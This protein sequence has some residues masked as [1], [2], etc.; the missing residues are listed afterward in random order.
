MVLLDSARECVCVLCGCTDSRACHGGCSWVK[1]DRD[2]GCGLCSA[3]D[4]D[5]ETIL[6]IPGKAGKPTEL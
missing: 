4:V 6:L 3:H 1:V 2:N 5:E